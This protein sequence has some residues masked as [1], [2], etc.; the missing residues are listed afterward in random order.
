VREVQ[1]DLSGKGALVTGGSGDLGRAIAMRLASRGAWVAITYANRRDLAE[2]LVSELRSTGV[3]ALAVQ[4][5]QATT[6]DPPQV[7]QA[8]IESWAGSTSWSTTRP[9][10]LAYRSRTWKR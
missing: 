10:T 1:A 9:G 4:L 2:G 8:V 3:G 6:E 5:D 7:I